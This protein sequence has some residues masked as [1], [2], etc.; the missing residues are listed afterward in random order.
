MN[1]TEWVE[2]LA[3]GWNV[4]TGCDETRILAAAGRP[5][6]SGARL[7]LYGDGRAAA[8]VVRVLLGPSPC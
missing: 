4:L 6:P 2:T 7:P 8:A 5:R 3:T 1:E